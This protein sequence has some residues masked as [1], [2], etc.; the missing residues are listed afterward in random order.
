C[1]LTP[2]TIMHYNLHASRA[3]KGSKSNAR[4][5]LLPPLPE[6]LALTTQRKRIEQLG[7]VPHRGR[8]RQYCPTGSGAVTARL[9][10]LHEILNN[11]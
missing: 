11:D 9:L 10:H 3:A 4:Q 7:S 5:L 8:F 1:P 2:C 6:N